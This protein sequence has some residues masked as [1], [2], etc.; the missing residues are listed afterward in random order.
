MT[1]LPQDVVDALSEITGVHEIPSHAI[2]V[3]Y[4]DIFKRSET[5][6]PDMP[7]VR[8][9]LR[10]VE[11]PKCRAL[12]PDPGANDPAVCNC[13]WHMQFDAASGEAA[14]WKPEP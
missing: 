14:I 6:L 4:G 10:W 7:N 12:G 5:P 1:N 2:R 13:G 11:C 3:V 9:V 8:K